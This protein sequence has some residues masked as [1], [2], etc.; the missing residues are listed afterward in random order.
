MWE[1]ANAEGMVLLRAA[2]L[3]GRWEELLEKVRQSCS[4][5]RRIDFKWT[6][7][8]MRA[9]LKAGATVEPPTSQALGNQHLERQTA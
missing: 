8:D 1:E 3:S 6:S 4:R 9:E 7:P 2:A 5:D